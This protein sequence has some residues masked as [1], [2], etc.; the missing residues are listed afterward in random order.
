[1][2]GHTSA[3][4]GPSSSPTCTS[5]AAS[6]PTSCAGADL[7]EPLL[8]ALRGRRPARDP[9]RRP[10][11]ARGARTATRS[12]S[13]APFFADVGARA[14]PRRRAARAR[15]ATTTTGSSAGWIDA[16]LQTEPAGFLGLE[17]RFEPPRPARSPRALAEAARPAPA[18]ARLPRPLAARR[19]LRAS[20][21]TTPT[22]HATVPTFERLA[23]GAMARWIVAAAR[24]RA[25]RRTTTR[26]CSRRC[27]PGCT[28]SRS[29]P[30]TRRVARAAA[31][32]RA[33]GSR[34]TG[35]AA[36]HPLR[37]RARRRLPRA[38]CARST[39]AGLGPL[40]A[41]PVTAPA[42]RRGYLHGIARGARGASDLG[43]PH[44]IWGHSH[45]SGPW[46]RRR[47]RGVDD[48][49]RRADPQHR[50]VGLPAALP[51]ARAERLALLAGHRRARR[52]TTGPPRLVRLLGDR[53]HDELR[54]RRPG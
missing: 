29:A 52:A 41:R 10:R 8:E 11:A 45:R 48:A 27:T 42:L 25:R 1:M 31:R 18:A 16:R 36:A 30:T 47:P 4:C 2:V 19:R 9:R 40:R 51:H 6:G 20:T 22:L 43:A 33:P 53:G 35:E 28:R 49:R 54:P 39:R 26:P 24:G 17:Q 38:R 50:L 21:A 12:T 13:P 3:R 46:P 34:S 37:A 7:R 23:A 14:R 32:R 15:A 5:A 44:V